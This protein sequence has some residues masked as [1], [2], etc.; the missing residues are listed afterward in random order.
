MKLHICVPRE[1]PQKNEGVPCM[2][3]TIYSSCIAE[4]M[5]YN[6]LYFDERYTKA[7]LKQVL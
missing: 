6:N 1:S 2:E 7:V 3:I 4:D 5:Q